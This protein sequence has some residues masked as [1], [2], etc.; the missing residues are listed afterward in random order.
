MARLCFTTESQC[1]RRYQPLQW[2][3]WLLWPQSLWYTYHVYGV[4]HMYSAIPILFIGNCAG[5]SLQQ[6]QT[7]RIL[8]FKIPTQTGR[9]SSHLQSITDAHAMFSCKAWRQI[10][11]KWEDLLHQQQSEELIPCSGLWK[12]SPTQYHIYKFILSLFNRK[13]ILE[14]LGV[15]YSGICCFFFTIML[16]YFLFSH[17][18][19]RE[20]IYKH[21]AGFIKSLKESSITHCN[22]NAGSGGAVGGPSEL[23]GDRGSLPR[24]YIVAVDVKGS[25]DTINQRKLL[26][27][28]LPWST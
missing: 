20:D 7:I 9:H 12:G 17:Y 2:T 26:Q 19:S 16:A 18:C 15:Q 28:S 8:L 13:H 5:D 11:W 27:V 14:L 6:R 23:M 10:A 1:G 21:L 4:S 3:P 22:N 24:L 25:F